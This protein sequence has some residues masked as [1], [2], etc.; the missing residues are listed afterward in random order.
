MS[1]RA[2]R[3]RNRKEIIRRASLEY[4]DA[5]LPSVMSAEAEQLTPELSQL[6]ALGL[7]NYSYSATFLEMVLVF[8]VLLVLQMSYRAVLHSNGRESSGALVKCI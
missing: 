1:L 3:H 4:L 5:W 7:N 6:S 8:L 2:L